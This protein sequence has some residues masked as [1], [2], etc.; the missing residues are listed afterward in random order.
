MRVL[1]VHHNADVASFWAMYFSR[2]DAGV[3]VAN[4]I[5]SAIKSLRFDAINV[6]ILD[7]ALPN[8]QSFSISDYAGVFH[9]KVPIVAISTSTFFS[10]T[11][12]FEM[13]PNARALMA[14]PLQLS[15]LKAI[16]DFYATQVPD[17][18]TKFRA[19]S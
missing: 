3:Q 17:K 9:P 12:L 16:V 15:D 19:A 14:M 13:M 2:Q 8:G 6:I 10:G 11:D 18:V 7:M 4:N 5:D 1:I